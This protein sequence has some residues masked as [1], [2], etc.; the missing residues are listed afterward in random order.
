MAP[1]DADRTN[2]LR[3]K[4][5]AFMTERKRE[6]AREFTEFS[7]REARRHYKSDPPTSLDD[8]HWPTIKELFDQNGDDCDGVDL[9]AYNLLRESGFQQGEIYRLVVRRER[10]KAYH[11]VTLWF[12]DRDDPWVLDATGAMTM[13]MRRFSELPPGWTPIVMFDEH[14]RHWVGKVQHPAAPHGSGRESR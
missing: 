10:K 4:F 14:E 7:Q 3:K 6:L 2:L 8:D 12:E 9:I 1:G 5:S 11:M 13:K